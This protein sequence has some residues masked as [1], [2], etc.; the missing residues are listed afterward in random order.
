MKKPTGIALLEILISVTVLSTGLIAVFRPLLVSLS[1]FTYADRRVEAHRLLKNFVWDLENRARE[2]GS[3][4]DVQ[5][6]GVLL[7][8]GHIYNY[9]LTVSPLDEKERL[10]QLDFVVRWPSGGYS[11]ELRRS[12]YLWIPYAPEA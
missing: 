2:D 9:D 1:A 3:L 6:A 5:T 7:G 8:R 10:H 12:F 4:S 11:K